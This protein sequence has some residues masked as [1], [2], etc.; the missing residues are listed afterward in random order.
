LR[1]SLAILLAI[2]LLLTAGRVLAAACEP[3]PPT[4]ASAPVSTYL[5][6]YPWTFHAPTRMALGAASSLLVSDPERERIV[7]RD[8]AGRITDSHTLAGRPISVAVDS[9]GRIY[10]GDADLGRVSVHSRNWDLL[11][12]LGIGTGEFQ[13]PVAI[14]VHPGDG[15]IYVVDSGSHQLRVFNSDGSPEFSIGGPGDGEG[16]FRY[17]AGIFVDAVAAEIFVVDQLN[18]RVQVFDLQGVYLRCI[19][20]STGRSFGPR[21]SLNQPQG[22]WVDTGRS[23][24]SIATAIPWQPSA[25]SVQG[26]V[27]CVSRWTWWWTS[28]N[29]CLSLP[30][31]MPAWK[32]SDS[33]ITR[34]RNR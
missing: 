9:Q 1:Q 6:S 3:G 13:L 22:V 24:Y 29:A 15:R 11:F 27:V 16:L 20:G 7:I 10:L 17:P 23:R 12:E 26:P 21:R 30:P 33:T 32:C 5:R 4:G 18:F 19:G 14:S 28:I 31:T 34:I 25:I 2:F 8:A